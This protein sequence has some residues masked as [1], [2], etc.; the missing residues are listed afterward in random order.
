MR[1][2][3]ALIMWP[4]LHDITVPLFHRPSVSVPSRNQN[5]ISPCDHFTLLV[6]PAAPPCHLPLTC[7]KLVAVRTGKTLWYYRATVPLGAPFCHLVGH[8]A[9]VPSG[10]IRC[11]LVLHSF[12]VPFWYATDLPYRRVAVLL[13][14][15]FGIP[16]YNC[17]W[18]LCSSWQ[19]LEQIYLIVCCY[20]QPWLLN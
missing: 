20:K 2:T 16:S 14:R 17:Q 19:S 15:Y 8:R 3:R 11:N 7:R 18:I 13:I 6:P 9:I 1:I 5:T 10:T 12:T 4:C